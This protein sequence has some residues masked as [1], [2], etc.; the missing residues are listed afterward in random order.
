MR[1]EKI[2]GAFIENKK[3]GW[4]IPEKGLVAFIKKVKEIITHKNLL[5][6]IKLQNKRIKH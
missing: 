3:A 2:A 1:Q 6:A 4:K 5:R